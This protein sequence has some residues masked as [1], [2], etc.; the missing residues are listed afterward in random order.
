MDVK[1]FDKLGRE[2]LLSICFSNKI[3]LVYPSTPPDKS[4]FQEESVWQ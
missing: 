3:I 4:P 1:F 2:S